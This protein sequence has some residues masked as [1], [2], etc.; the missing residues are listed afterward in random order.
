MRQDFS[1]TVPVAVR[2]T[3]VACRMLSANLAKKALTTGALSLPQLQLGVGLLVPGREAEL[4]HAVHLHK[5][6]VKLEH[7]HTEA[8]PDLGAIRSALM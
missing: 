4:T 2:Q 3:A 5:R 8:Q 6:V 7:T 1:I